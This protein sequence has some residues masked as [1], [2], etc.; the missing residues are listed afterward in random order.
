MCAHGIRWSQPLR[1]TM[2]LLNSNIRSSFLKKRENMLL[3][4][5]RECF[6]T[7]RIVMHFHLLTKMIPLII[8]FSERF[9][10]ASLALC[11]IIFKSASS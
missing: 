10:R 3:M 8:Q 1:R 7:I 4:Q 2:K 6:V 11:I 9:K 5:I